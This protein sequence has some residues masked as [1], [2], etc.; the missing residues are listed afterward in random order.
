MKSDETSEWLG[1][2]ADGVTLLLHI[3][4]RA[5]RNAVQ[6]VYGS[7]LKVRLTAPPV[8]GAANRALA[9][10]LAERLGVRRQQIDIVT[11][12]HSRQKVVRVAG[13]TAE[14]VWA[15]LWRQAGDSDR[16]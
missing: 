11:G 10:F 12:Q 6:G 7:S 14:H 15:R 5:R 2:D 8:E 9:E 13:V 16:P 3:T 1:V 4:P